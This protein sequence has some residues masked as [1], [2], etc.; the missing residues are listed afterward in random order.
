MD[1]G[2]CPIKFW[3]WGGM[4]LDPGSWDGLE[5]GLKIGPVKTS[6]PEISQ[7]TGPISKFQT[8]FDSPVREQPVQG[9]KFNPEVTDDVTGQIQHGR[10]WGATCPRSDLVGAAEPAFTSPARP[11][12]GSATPSSS[13]AI[14]EK[15]K[16]TKVAFCP[17]AGRGLYSRVRPQ[18]ASEWRHVPQSLTKNKGL[19]ESPPRHVF[20][21]NPKLTYARP[22]VWVTYARPGGGA[23]DRPPRELEN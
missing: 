16:N 10:Q 12:E 17:P 13:G 19:R 15:K 5:L 20:S 3:I 1:W 14:S 23:D 6:T 11:C 22:G 21:F 7:T 8:P 9:Q 2:G 4:D 18:M